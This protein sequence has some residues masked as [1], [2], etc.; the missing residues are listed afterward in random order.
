MESENIDEVLQE[1]GQANFQ[2][3][4]RVA[5]TPVRKTFQEIWN[6]AQKWDVSFGTGSAS[7]LKNFTVDGIAYTDRPL[8]LSDLAS[9]I[10]S[11][12]ANSI[13]VRNEIQTL[14]DNVPLAQY[15]HLPDIDALVMNG[16][17]IDETTLETQEVSLPSDEEVLPSL[18]IVESSSVGGSY[19]RSS[20]KKKK[21]TRI[22]TRKNKKL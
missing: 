4:D 6:A 21:S 13:A 16:G 17:L 15:K 19:K 9:L 2:P 8:L 10:V 14:F 1:G 18:D 20:H 3:S 5:F 12:G 11:K 22:R 7:I